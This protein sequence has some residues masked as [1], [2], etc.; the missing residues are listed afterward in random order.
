[1]VLTPQLQ[2][3]RANFLQQTSKYKNR[4]KGG[5]KDRVI[6]REVRDNALVLCNKLH[7]LCNNLFFLKTHQERLKVYNHLIVSAH[8][9]H[10]VILST[11][12]TQKPEDQHRLKRWGIEAPRD[13]MIYLRP[14]GSCCPL[15]WWLQHQ[16]IPPL[17]WPSNTKGQRDWQQRSLISYSSTRAEHWH[18]LSHTDSQTFNKGS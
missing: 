14:H 8:H 1:M 12:Q 17:L 6:H 13:K 16:N 10:P 4:H 5:K 11:L 15:A 3:H 7:L 2:Y 18:G 9:I